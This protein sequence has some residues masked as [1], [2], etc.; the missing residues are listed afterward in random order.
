MSNDITVELTRAI[1]FTPDG[2][3]ELADGDFVILRE[4]TAAPRELKICSFLK[5][6]FFIMSMEVAR[7]GK[8]E[9]DDVVESTDKKTVIAG[10]EI[11]YGMYGCQSIDMTKV[12]EKA[13]ELFK[14]VGKIAGAKLLTDHM[15]NSMYPEDLEKLLGEYMVNF[16]LRSI[17]SKT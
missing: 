11:I 5:Q 1:K 13:K 8:E 9:K 3:G 12:L 10:T 15:L 16:I 6:Q 17:L 2:S 7:N 14:I 4:P